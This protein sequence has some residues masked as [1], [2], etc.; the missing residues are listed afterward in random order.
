MQPGVPGE[1][2]QF[3]VELK[4]TGLLIG[5]CALK[6]DADDT[7]QAEIGYTFARE[8]QG[9]GYAAEAVACL[10]DYAFGTLNLHR[11]IALV[12]CEN[13]RSVALLHRLGLRREGHFIQDFW[14]KG[15]WVDEYQYAILE[16]EW[17]ARRTYTRQV[18]A[19]A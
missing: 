17:L 15:S 19:D 2:F 5:D 9:K 4:E 14:H 11:V 18:V 3:A 6:V 1:W 7:Q 12:I 8:H 10:L 16:S 13:Q